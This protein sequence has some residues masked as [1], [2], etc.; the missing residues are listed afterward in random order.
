MKY[1]AL[2]L[3][4][5]TVV[6]GAAVQ[7]QAPVASL[8][9]QQKTAIQ[10]TPEL[11]RIMGS[12]LRMTRGRSLFE[13]MTDR[14]M[15]LFG[16]GDD[17]EDDYSGGDYFYE[18]DVFGNGHS[19]YAFYNPYHGNYQPARDDDFGEDESSYSWSDFFFDVGMVAGPLLGVALMMPTGLLTIP[20]GRSLDNHIEDTL[21]PFELPL[22]DAVEKADFLS[23][24][25]R[26]C[27]SR[28]F[29]EVS[30]IGRNNESSLMQKLV[31]LTANLT[32]DHLSE[33][34][35]FKKLFKASRD[36]VCEIYKCV[37]LMTPG[38]IF[39]KFS[40]KALLGLKQQ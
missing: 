25:T 40:S 26:D 7:E 36:G 6:L 28:I 19:S 13:T 35:G 17:Y 15:N 34:Y 10:T 2:V 29:C 4:S 31:Y 14:V 23:Y 38:G 37:P 22:L 33:S 3:A 12:A 32:P 16:Y 8:E 21:K 1:F 5:A 27:Q 11:N 18:P 20:T 24:T 30:K 39:D 9:E